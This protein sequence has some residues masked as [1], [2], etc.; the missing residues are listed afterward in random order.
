MRPVQFLRAA[1]VTAALAAGASSAF[2]QAAAPA[3]ATPAA[4]SFSAAQRSDIEGLV[5]SYL[6]THPEIIKEALIELQRKEKA[7]EAAARAKIVQDPAG[8]LYDSPH[9][10]VVGNPNGKVT[11]VEFFDYNC[12]FCKRALDDLTK[13]MKAEPNL[14]VILKD[15][16][17]LGPKSVEAAQVSIAARKQLK[18]EKYFEFHQKLLN[19][20]GQIGRA[21][22]LA[23]AKT[24]GLDLT[25]LAA[26][27]EDASVRE[28]VSETMTLGDALGLTGTPSYIVGK[29]VVIGAVGYDELKQHLDDAMKK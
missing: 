4:S 15:F 7:D 8:K 9:H 19:Q 11:V 28:A 2:A 21:E 22:G 23:V 26:D 13:L 16:P 5:R 18:G 10:A 12:G 29:D 6:L 1:L 24:M 25:K 17:V 3:T 14:K 20:K 27:M